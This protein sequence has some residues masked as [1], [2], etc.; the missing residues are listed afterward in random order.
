VTGR[1]VAV[2]GRPADVE[3]AA[4]ALALAP[5]GNHVVVHVTGVDPVPLSL[6][7]PA[8]QRARQAAATLEAAGICATARGRLAVVEA[9]EPDPDALVARVESE[10]GA[11]PV[12]AFLRS[13]A[14]ADERLLER[15]AV[16]L[17]GGAWDSAAALLVRELERR[18]VP[19]TV[20]APPSGA[21]AVL[22]RAGLRLPAWGAS[23]GQASVETVALLPLLLA[24]V[25]AAGQLLA[26]GV[27]RE[28]A[29]H[30]ATAGAAALIQGRDGA[31]AARRALPGW[32][33]ARAVVAVSGRRVSVRMRPPGVAPL[34]GLLEARRVADAGPAP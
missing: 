12:V 27:A 22:A 24:A 5:A 6:G 10:I 31:G 19:F 7:L 15:S 9:S 17:C 18:R 14:P 30:A 8:T 29:G 1:P 26:A 23:P 4:A 28:L 2:L 13:R 21:A 32:S 34:A 33:R 16:T 3:A 20:E 11:A 25:L